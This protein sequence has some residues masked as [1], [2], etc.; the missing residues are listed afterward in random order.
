M[1]SIWIDEINLYFQFERARHVVILIF[2]TTKN[3]K[4]RTTS[5]AEKSKT[6]NRYSVRQKYR[7]RYLRKNTPS[8]N[9][10]TATILTDQFPGI[11]RSIGRIL[12]PFLVDKKR[13]VRMDSGIRKGLGQRLYNALTTFSFPEWPQLNLN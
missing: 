5:L 7:Q 4:V 8:C 12:L 3:A 9:E 6:Y 10:C 2:A 11:R 13:A 1:G